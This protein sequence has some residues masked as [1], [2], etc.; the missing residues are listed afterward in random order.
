MNVVIIGFLCDEEKL[1]IS[2]ISWLFFLLVDFLVIKFISFSFI[3]V[4]LVYI[5]YFLRV[6][7]VLLMF[8]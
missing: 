4:F 2:E 5:M 1:W 8:L 3:V 6:I 7:L